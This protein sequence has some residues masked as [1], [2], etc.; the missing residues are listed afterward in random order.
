LFFAKVFDVRNIT[1]NG[2]KT[3]EDDYVL[4]EIRQTMEV[5]TLGYLRMQENILFFDGEALAA[6]LSAEFP[7]LKTI[8]IEKKL[9]HELIINFFE[10]MPSG[11]WCFDP[12][13][14]RYFDSEGV[15]WGEPVRSSGFLLLMIDDLRKSDNQERI[16][17]DFFNGIR[18][19][20]ETL[21]KRNISTKEAGIPEDSV[22]DFY[23]VA[24]GG[25]RLIFNLDT[26]IEGQVEVLKIFLNDKSNVD[27]RPQYIDLRIDGR[28]YYK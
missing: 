17:I 9:R 5:K 10:R 28:V 7:V 24:D 4:R 12:G 18:L 14:C 26:D 27:F 25:Y 13:K 1:I 6:K 3:V 20:A 15:L 23:L 22:M 8:G 19:A 2:L 16:D 11:I 21:K